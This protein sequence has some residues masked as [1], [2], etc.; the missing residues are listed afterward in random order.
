MLSIYF[1]SSAVKG[2]EALA[3]LLLAKVLALG[4]MEEISAMSKAKL[5]QNP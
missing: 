3:V 5:V 2:K 4:T 1:Y